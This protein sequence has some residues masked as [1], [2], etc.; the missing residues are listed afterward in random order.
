MSLKDHDARSVVAKQRNKIHIQYNIILKLKRNE[1]G[2]ISCYN[3]RI[4]VK[5]Y[6]QRVVAETYFHV[7]YFTTVRTDTVLE[8]KC[9]LH[10]HHLDARK[11]FLHG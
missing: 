3:E 10:M 4:L 7:V 1:E 9:K 8:S 6:I 5:D 2:E 11:T